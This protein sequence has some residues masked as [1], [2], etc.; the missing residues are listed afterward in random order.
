MVPFTMI[1]YD[2]HVLALAPDLGSSIVVE[3]CRFLDVSEGLLAVEGG[4]ESGSSDRSL[5]TVNRA[6][7]ALFFSTSPFIFL[8]S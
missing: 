2:H 4:S 5:N 1:T 8:S 3:G 7:F 6:M